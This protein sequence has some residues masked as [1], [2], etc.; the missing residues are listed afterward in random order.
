MCGIA[1]IVAQRPDDLRPIGA[2]I[3]ALRHRGP[4]DEG[5]YLAPDREPGRVFST[6][7][8][9]ARQELPRF[10]TEIDA[11]SRVALGHRR[12][13]IVDLSSGG[14]QPMTADA[15]DVTITYN[16]EIYNY[17]ELREELRALGHTFRTDSDT[18]VILA[19]WEEWREAPHATR[20]SCRSRRCT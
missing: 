9:R 12:L 5:I 6:D 18:E 20:R 17:V 13:S 4:D 16:G 11:R 8:T 14:F 1:G 7:A 3:R 15:T 2:M 19:A 10:G